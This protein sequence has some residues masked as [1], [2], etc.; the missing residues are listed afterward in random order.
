[1][2]LKISDHALVRFLERAYGCDIDDVRAVLSELL[3]RAEGAAGRI[4]GGAYAIKTLGLTF[5]VRDKTV[6]T[7]LD[8]AMPQNDPTRA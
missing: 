1:M 4:G 3:T 2:S 5:I 6:V 8:G 7:V